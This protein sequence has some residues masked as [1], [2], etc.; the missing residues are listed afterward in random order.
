MPITENVVNTVA[1]TMTSTVME[2]VHMIFQEVLM[3]SENPHTLDASEQ[4]A[5]I[6]RGKKQRPYSLNS[7]VTFEHTISIQNTAPFSQHALICIL[8][9][10]SAIVVVVFSTNTS[11]FV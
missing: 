5:V 3:S 8:Y 4:D 2:K 11:F 6:G 1:I 10:R 7:Y 9:L